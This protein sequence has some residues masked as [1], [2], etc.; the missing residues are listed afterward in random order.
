MENTRFLL[1]MKALG[2]FQVLHP[3]MLDKLHAFLV[4][5][6]LCLRA[7]DHGLLLPCLNWPLVLTPENILSAIVNLCACVHMKF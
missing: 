2:E 6:S 7:L 3:S 1:L 5:G 4:R